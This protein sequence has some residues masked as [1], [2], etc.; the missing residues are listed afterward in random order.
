M[1]YSHPSTQHIL[2]HADELRAEAVVSDELG[3]LSDGTVQILRDSGGMRLLQAE[4]LGGF[5]E[6][7]NTFMEWVM[8]VA[9][10][11]PSAGWVAGVVGIHPWEISIADPV[12]QNEI[13]GENPDTWVASPYAPFGRAR[14]VEGDM[15]SPGAG[16]TPPVPTSPSGRSSVV[17]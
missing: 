17:S 6:H 12:L 1:S 11:H 14:P 9:S 3:R 13:Y 5:E 8:A 7:P 4:D 2:D 10:H 16:P 15:S